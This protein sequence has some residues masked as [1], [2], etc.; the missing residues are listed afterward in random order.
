MSFDTTASNRGVNTGARVLLE[1]KNK[2]DLISLACRH[3]ILEIIIERVFNALMETS[4]GPNI[5]LFQRFSS[6]WS[7]INIKKY[8]SGITKDTVA[9]ELKPHKNDL[10]K[11][12]KDQLATYQPRDD[13]REL[14]QLSLIFLGD[15]TARCFNIRTPGAL[16]RARW[17]A[18]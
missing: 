9:N 1:K 4:N 5:R 13:Y 10:V 16:H 15:K 6:N 12:I 2:K 17:M 7:Q 14:L 8:E 11:F 3:H 18:K